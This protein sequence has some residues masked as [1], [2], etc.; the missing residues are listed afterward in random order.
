MKNFKKSL[1]AALTAIAMAFAVPAASFSAILPTYAVG[2]TATITVSGA[3]SSAVFNAYQ[4]FQGD[5][6]GN[7]ITN[8]E[9]GTGVNGNGLLSTLQND[10]TELSNGSTT[11]EMGSLFTNMTSASQVANVLSGVGSSN[12]NVSD[13]V[14]LAN[15]AEFLK[16]FVKDVKD[17]LSSSAP[18]YTMNAG[19]NFTVSVVPG[20]YLVVQQDKT[21]SPSYSSSILQVVNGTSTVSVKSVSPTTDKLVSTDL[22]DSSDTTASP[23]LPNKYNFKEGADHNIGETFKYKLV[24]SIPVKNLYAYDSYPLTITDTLPKGVNYMGNIQVFVLNGQESTDSNYQ[25]ITNATGVTKS[26]PDEGKTGDIT[27]K[28]PDLLDYWTGTYQNIEVI[29]TFDAQ[30]NANAETTTETGPGNP[31]TN[32]FV[33]TYPNDPENST[34]TGTTPE[35]SADVYTYEMTNTKRINTADGN[36]LAGAKFELY[37]GTSATGSPITFTPVYKTGST[38]EVDYYV[39]DPKGTTTVLTSNSA[40]Q[41]NIKGLD[42]GNYYLVETE[43]PA[44]YVKPSQGWVITI[45]ASIKGVDANTSDQT[46]NIVL[47]EDITGN[48]TNVSDGELDNN[49]INTSSSSLPSTGGAGTTAFYTI[50]GCL[51]AGAV[52]LYV[53]NKR[54][55]KED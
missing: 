33:L 26:T 9:W 55:K 53:T 13:L 39:V 34:S 41:F 42:R 14:T 35:E 18:T 32:S 2:E 30:L 23:F 20:Y 15:S 22:V 11:I 36:T 28:I 52:V 43:A 29:V 19:N 6:S 21:G 12:S 45:N 10:D 25:T 17:N 44:G 37:Q 50:G 1:C 38:T 48:G 8:I 3:D 7:T 16:E 47:T 4:I 27:V 49:I 54:M 51:V 24:A 31:N 46:D 5:V 40:G